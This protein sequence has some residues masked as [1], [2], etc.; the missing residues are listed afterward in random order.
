MF[1]SRTQDSG[2]ISYGVRDLSGRRWFVK[3]PGAEAPSAGGTTREE[4]SRALELAAEVSSAV[5]HP[6]LIPLDRII[7]TE[8]GVVTV[9]AWFD[10]EL[11]RAPAELRD[12]PEHAF[13]R[14]KSL[15]TNEIVAALDAIIELHVRLGEEGWIAGDLYDGCLMY[16]FATRAIKVMD[17]ECYHRGSYVNHVGRLPGSTRFMAPEESTKGAVIDC[18]TTVF[19]LGRMIEILLLERNPDHPSRDVVRAA[20][21]E[22]P[23]KRPASLADFHRA[24]RAASGLIL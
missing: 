24:W 2:H 21:S 18:R 20:T 5:E 7:E 9:S 1:D 19:N 23:S 14:F 12:D 11:V 10:G 4:R 17:F 13:S 8:E 22:D 15:P 6:A 16:D 3:T